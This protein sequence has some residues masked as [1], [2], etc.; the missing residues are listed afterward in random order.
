MQVCA[1]TVAYN[2]PEELARLLCSLQSQTSL[3]GL[4]LLDNSREEY[5]K[6]N[7]ALFRTHADRYQFAHFVHPRENIGSAGAFCQGMKIAHEK[8]F[9]WIWL[10]DQDGT[11]ENGCLAS[12]LRNTGQADI[13]CPQI[14][15]IDNPVI[16]LPQSGA[17]QNFW[18]RMVWIAFTV[19]RNISF[20]ATHGALISK[21]VLDRIGYYD[22]HN[23]FVGSEDSDYAFRATAEHMV[24][25]LVVEAKARHPDAR[26]RNIEKRRSLTD[27]GLIDNISAERGGVAADHLSARLL[28]RL[29]ESTLRGSRLLPEHLGYVNSRLF[30]DKNCRKTQGFASLSYAY[31]ATKRLTSLQ[32]GAACTYSL[33]IA[34]FRKLIGDSRISLKGTVSMYAICMRSKLRKEW[35]FESIEQF[36]M[37]LAE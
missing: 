30:R 35:P 6:E 27:A 12:L 5:L 9:D 32:L 15:H 11:V 36:C 17:I 31:L 33:L 25:R 8:G 34:S 13:L 23:F 19:S 26:H 2:N 29:Q 21:S 37:R 14:V 16:V 18:G 20:F 4:I 28:L 3:N 22:P 1:I 7:E 24:I 10:L